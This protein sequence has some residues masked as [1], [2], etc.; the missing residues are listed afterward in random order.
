MLT[1]WITFLCVRLNQQ[2]WRCQLFCIVISN[3]FLFRWFQQ[4]AMTPF[5]AVSVEIWMT[6]VGR[7]SVCVSI[8]LN[9]KM[10]WWPREL[11]APVKAKKSTTLC[12]DQG[13][14]NI[15]IT[16]SSFVLSFFKRTMMMGNRKGFS[17]VFFAMTTL[18]ICCNPASAFVN[19]TSN[20]ATSKYQPLFLFFISL[21]QSGKFLCV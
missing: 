16:A 21:F 11:Q 19:Q 1:G 6:K 3:Q 13:K 14:S 18:L 20:Q 17:T 15:P 7:C 8:I 5:C 2:V 12:K 10:N 4:R 9:N